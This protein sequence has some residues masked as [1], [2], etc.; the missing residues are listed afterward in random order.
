MISNLFL[1]SLPRGGRNDRGGGPDGLVLVALD[2][3]DLS[4]VRP[5]LQIDGRQLPQVVAG[6]LKCM[7]ISLPANTG[8]VML[9]IIVIITCMCVGKIVF[10][11]SFKNLSFFNVYR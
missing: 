9:N 11:S 10:V 1:D 3:L 6:N 8:R 5:R 7:H 2:V 4:V